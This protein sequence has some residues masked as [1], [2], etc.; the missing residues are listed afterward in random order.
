MTFPDEKRG[1]EQEKTT[2][3]YYENSEKLTQININ[4][5]LNNHS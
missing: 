3:V 4:A 1:C 2:T 5:Y